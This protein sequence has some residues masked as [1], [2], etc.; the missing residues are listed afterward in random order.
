LQEGEVGANDDAEAGDVPVRWS[1]RI[2]VC[3]TCMTG[4]IDG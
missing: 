1:C 4:L 3:H 2:G